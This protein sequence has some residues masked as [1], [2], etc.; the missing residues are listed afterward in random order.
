MMTLSRWKVILV[1]LAVLF[2]VVFTLPNVLPQKTLDSLPSWAPKQKLNLGLD[3]Q[4]GSSLLLEV[5]TASLK[6]ERLSSLLEDVRNALNQGSIV[7]DGLRQQGDAVMV[8]I[9][10]AADM[11]KAYQALAKLS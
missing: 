1:T 10:N 9:V 2:G 11:D 6:A 3:L 7:Y 5:D 8:H 4:G